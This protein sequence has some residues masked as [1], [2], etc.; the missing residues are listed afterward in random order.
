MPKVN[1]KYVE[2]SPIKRIDEGS[3]WKIL[4]ALGI[5]V[6]LGGT[7]LYWKY[8]KRHPDEKKINQ[9]KLLINKSFPIAES[10]LCPLTQDKTKTITDHSISMQIHY[11]SKLNNKL[12][13]NS[14]STRNPFLPPF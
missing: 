2:E 13:S 3:K 12:R 8:K 7:L 6:A 5:V 14:S 10:S 4:I 9:L 11:I 1:L